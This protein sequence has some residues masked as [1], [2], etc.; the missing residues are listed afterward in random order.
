MKRLRILAL[1]TF[2]LAQLSC[3]AAGLTPV[4][5]TMPVA[6]AGLAPEYRVFYD[7]LEG[8]GD[9]TLIEPYG[10]VF[11]PDVNFVAWRPYD[12]GFWAPTDVYGWVWISS[13]PFGW[14]TYHYGQWMYDRFQGWVWLPGLDWGPA[15]VAWQQ[16]DDYVGWAPLTPRGYDPGLL[17]GGGY[18]YV[19]MSAMGATDLRAREVP[20]VQVEPSLENAKPVRNVVTRGGVAINLGPSIDLVERAAGPLPRVKLAEVAPAGGLRR[21]GAGAAARAGGS[22]DPIDAT[23][24]AAEAA[25]DQARAI[26]AEGGSLPQRVS[27]LR[28]GGAPGGR[29]PSATRRAPGRGRGAPRDST[30]RDSTAN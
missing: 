21:G 20:R 3:A 8:Y 25:A 27:I 28:P 1:L 2:A 7:A 29:A 5:T 15:W 23:R 16:T 10:Y 18:T 12:D 19:P 9:W 17:P 14:A 11:R 13:E 26:S 4:K 22:E 6:R 24:R 30:A